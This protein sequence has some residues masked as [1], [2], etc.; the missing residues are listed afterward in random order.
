M[1]K[2]KIQIMAI[3]AVTCCC[4]VA[5]DVT[6][7]VNAGDPDKTLEASDI[8]GLGA[9]DN[10]VKEGGGRLIIDSAVFG[11]SW[12]G[13]VG[14]SNGYLRVA[15]VDA[16]GP[17]GAKGAV[18]ANGATIEFDGTALNNAD[19]TCAKVAFEGEGADG[20]SAIR[21]V[22]ANWGHKNMAWTLTGPA[23]WG[24]AL[25]ATRPTATRESEARST[26]RAD[27]PNPP[28]S[29]PGGALFECL[30]F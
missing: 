7:T 18:V 8:A 12:S 11:A 2:K 5:A 28:G 22:G 25:R 26:G 20:E 17:A 30:S 9:S 19:L 14:V 15:H 4:A 13:A 27:C 10:L 16:L 1:D 23:T 21:V 29:S 6:I 3:S 24:G